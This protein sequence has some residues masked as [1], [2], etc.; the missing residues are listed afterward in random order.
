VGAIGNH[1]YAMHWDGERWRRSRIA[2]PDTRRIELT[3][4][5]TSGRNN[6]WAL[7]HRIRHDVVTFYVLRWDGA[8]WSVAHSWDPSINGYLRSI[9]TAGPNRVFAVGDQPPANPPPFPG[10]TSQAYIASWNG[11]VWTSVTPP[12]SGNEDLLNSVAADRETAV[13]VGVTVDQQEDQAPF[14]LRLTSGGWVVEPTRTL[15]AYSRLDA[16]ATSDGE[17]VGVGTWARD[18]SEAGDQPHRLIETSTTGPWQRIRTHG[19]P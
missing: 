13:A 14:A 5:S 17:S 6:T 7:G 10:A 11:K 9:A 16:V 18:V 4:V 19:S 8:D 12:S 2:I 15:Q 1:P 3:A